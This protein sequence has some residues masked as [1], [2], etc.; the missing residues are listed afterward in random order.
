MNAE[1][2]F[3]NLLNDI[4]PDAIMTVPCERIKWIYEGIEYIMVSRESEGVA[5]ASGMAC[6]G[7]KPLLLIQSNGFGECV[8]T[9]M[10]LNKIYDIPIFMMISWR[11][12]E[13]E[14][15]APAI[16]LGRR[17]PK[18]LD[19]M[20]IDYTIWKNKND[21]KE[22]IIEHFEN[23]FEKKKIYV[24]LMDPKLWKKHND[25]TPTERRDVRVTLSMKRNMKSLQLRRYDVI[26]EI[27]SDVKDELVVCCLGYASKELYT[28]K[29]RDENFYMLGSMG[30]AIPFALGVS[31]FTTK[32]VIVF[33]GDGGLMSNLGCL[34][35]V[36]SLSKNNLRIILLDNGVHGSTGNQKSSAFF[37]D[38]CAVAE[39]FGLKRVLHIDSEKKMDRWKEGFFVHVPIT[40]GNADCPCIPISCKDITKRFSRSVL[41]GNKMSKLN[42]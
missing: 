10:S 25:I 4:N 17:L 21:L 23:T 7:A 34:S 40:P 35:S 26:Q 15:T 39:C 28:I 20:D 18:I 11:G 6:A 36:S 30:Q 1:E 29:D 12:L 38:L 19:A 41:L 31:L 22:D 13:E 37:V 3:I 14:T 9:I 5:I 8:N 24:V 33:E 32:N 2:K 42:E 16:P 27:M